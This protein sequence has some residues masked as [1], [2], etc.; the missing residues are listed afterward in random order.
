[1]DRYMNN[2]KGVSPVVATVLL[3]VIVIIIAV[4]IYL[5]ARGFL[6]EQAQK[7]GS[8]VEL[9][10]DDVNLDVGVF[11]E[12]L[13]LINRGNVP[14]YGFNIKRRTTGEIL[15]EDRSGTTIA[16]GES[17]RIDLDET[18]ESGDEFNIVPVLLGET[19]EGRVAH[20]CDDRHGIAFSVN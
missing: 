4:I 9:S 11:G 1:M 16:L 19:D 12:S 15:V 13:E 7:D 8:A 3:I 2:R 10:C 5:W 6:L 18:P 17:R 20:I 14:I